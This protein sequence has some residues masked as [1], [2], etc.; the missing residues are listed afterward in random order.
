MADDWQKGGFGIYLHWPFCE[1]KC[2]YCDFNSHV[3]RSIDHARWQSA[4]LREIDRYAELVPGRVLS[5]VF[6]GGGTPSLM[7]PETVAALLERIRRRWPVANDLEVTL[8]ANPGSVEAGR[9]AAFAQAGV[10][11]VSIGVQALNDPDLRRLGR[12]HTVADALRAIDLAKRSFPRVSFDLIYGR[13]GQSARQWSEE[14][15]QALAVAGEHL[16]LYQLTIEPGT[17]FAERYRLGK[18][19]DLPD[20]KLAAEL[21]DQTQDLCEA[22]GYSAYEVSNHSLPGGE[23]RHNL[24]Y[25][26]YGDYVGIGPGAHGRLT[27]AGR[28]LATETDLQPS[29]WLEAVESRN[30]ERCA[31]PLS[32][33]DQGTEYA[34]MSIRLSEGLDMQRFALISGHEFDHATLEHLTD[35]GLIEIDDHRLKPTRRGRLVLDAVIARLLEM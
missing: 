27:V 17:A 31:L 2:P 7:K 8:E 1:S 33:R 26:R 11:R 20:E 10:S 13:Q 24:I 19:R 28:R 9:F 29:T 16:S 5:S 6:F 3:A 22:S 23:C 18:L 25:W 21:Y 14:L 35:L 4:Y 34:L 32:P 15:S 30:G 12:L